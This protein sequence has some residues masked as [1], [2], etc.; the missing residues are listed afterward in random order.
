MH[1]AGA[2]SFSMNVA[3]VAEA[4]R[5]L[6]TL[7]PD[8]GYRFLDNDGGLMPYVCVFV[9][10]VHTPFEVWEQAPLEQSAELLIVPPIVGG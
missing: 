9:N 6:V 4:I 10:S 3:T 1:T 7:H 5:C 8:I 2:A